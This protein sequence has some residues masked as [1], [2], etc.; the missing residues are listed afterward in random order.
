MKAIL[1]PAAAILAA[2]S[3]SACQS[4]PEVVDTRPRNPLEAELRN[5]P[6]VE[7]PPAITAQVTF[8]CRDNSL[9]YVE[10]F[11]GDTQVSVRAEQDAP[12]TI[13]RAPEPGQPFVAEGYSLSGDPRNITLTQPGKPEQTCRA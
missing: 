5:A 3:L 7:L 8:R 9:A 1:P 13:L 2:L 11:Q 10:F 6:A 4:E 12:R